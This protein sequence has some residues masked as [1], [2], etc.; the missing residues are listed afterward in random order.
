MKRTRKHL[1]RR[2]AF[3]LLEVLMVVVILGLLAAFV[4]PNFFGAQEGAQEG[5]AEAA[6]KSSIPKA[7]QMYQL[8]MGHYPTDED[9][10][11]RA[12]V[13]KP[14][15]EDLAKKW[16]GPYIQDVDGLKDPWGHEYEYKCPGDY[17]EDS[18]DLSSNGKNGTA[19]DDDDIVNWKKS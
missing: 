18:F 14:D 7:L 10:G 13:E 3:T 17:N 2:R 1:L 15:D 5:L 9:G 4:V 16:R 12:L 6:V 8:H 19:G 11:L